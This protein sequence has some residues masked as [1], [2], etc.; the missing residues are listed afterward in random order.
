MSNDYGISG[1]GLLVEKAGYSEIRSSLVRGS[2]TPSGMLPLPVRSITE[3]SETN[4]SGNLTFLL[5]GRPSISD[6][7]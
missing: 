3:R 7:F 6:V 1:E 5:A 4:S 2:I